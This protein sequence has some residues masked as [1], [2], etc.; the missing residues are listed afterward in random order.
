MLRAT[1]FAL[2]VLWMGA[3]PWAQ[4]TKKQK[5]LET[6]HDE[7]KAWV[8]HTKEG[9]VDVTE[10]AHFDFADVL[11]DDGQSYT[12]LLVL[13]KDH[14]ERREWQDGISGTVT[15]TA[16]TLS[17]SDNR[18]QRW[19]LRSPG[20][21]GRPLPD[22]GMFLVSSW[23]CC[24]APFENI[25]FS[26]LSGKRLYTTNGVPDKGIF[27]QDSGLVRIDGGYD[28]NRYSQTRFIGFGAVG[29]IANQVPTLQYGTDQAIKQRISLLGR[30]YGDNFDVPKLLITQDDKRLES[31]LELN[32]PFNCVV[33][34]QFDHS[35]EVRIPVENDVMRLDKA[36][37]PPGYSLRSEPAP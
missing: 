7:S 32:G 8:M 21:T 33:V 18:N 23:P 10:N 4:A 1:A 26:L 9:D 17:Q 5:T 16:W 28:G 13:H 25:Y 12:R 6:P 19:T 30:E 29:H 37:L 31:Y 15:V 3:I 11:R 36:T 2:C 14:N 27:G 24:S 34:L 35:P 22:L 20:N